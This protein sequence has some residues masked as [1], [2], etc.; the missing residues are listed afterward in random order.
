MK[1][2]D[3]AIQHE[4][5][6]DISI[7]VLNGGFPHVSPV[8]RA[9]QLYENFTKKD[10]EADCFAIEAEVPFLGFTSQ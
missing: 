5:Y 3:I 2:E 10:P 7:Q 4:F 8:E 1:K 9:Q 6:Q